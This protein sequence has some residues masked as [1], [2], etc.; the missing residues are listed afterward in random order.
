MVTTITTVVG[1]IPTAYGIGGYDSLLAEMML[2]MGWGL[3]IGTAITLI[4]I[5]TI[6]SFYVRT[7][8]I[9]AA[10]TQDQITSSL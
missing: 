7:V 1:V 8:R 2:T 9:E 3:L 10:H 4:L 6:Y 5:P